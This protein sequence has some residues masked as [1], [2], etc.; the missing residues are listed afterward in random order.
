MK[1]LTT[2]ILLVY[3]FVFF[4]S[5]HVSCPEFDKTYLEWLP[6]QQ[7]DTITFINLTNDSTFEFYITDVYITHTTSYNT[8]M[9]CGE[10]SNTIR[11]NPF[12]EVANDLS[13]DISFEENRII[14]EQYTIKVS[15][16]EHNARNNS[17]TSSYS[18]LSDYELNGTFYDEVKIFTNYSSSGSFT[19][20]ILAQGFGIIAL[21]DLEE[22]T[23]I[24][25]QSTTTNFDTKSVEIQNS[26]CE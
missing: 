6:Y 18:E 9:D 21:I 16:F 2:I 13:I 7:G 10:C 22:N 3:S 25:K 1:T 19:E 12:I 17:S 5:S 8:R 23:W 20:I 4:S 11:I 14:E 24:L 15:Y 26:S